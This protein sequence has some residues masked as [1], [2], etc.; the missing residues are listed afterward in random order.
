ML[1]WLLMFVA[2]CRCVK[3]QVITILVS[4]T[5]A[6][7]PWY[8]IGPF[9]RQHTQCTHCAR[10][11]LAPVMLCVHAQ[12]PSHHA[13]ALLQL[14]T[15][16]NYSFCFGCCT[17]ACK[18]GTAS[19]LALCTPLHVLQVGLWIL[20]STWQLFDCY[21]KNQLAQHPMFAFTANQHAAAA[22]HMASQPAAAP[23]EPVNPFAYGGTPGSYQPPVV[24]G[25]P[26]PQHYPTAAGRV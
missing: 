7:A 26:A 19:D 14:C 9:F 20:W 16:C 3:F 13:A 24:Q 15:C 25:Y 18:L 21:R 12:Q 6:A 23:A 11:M 8:S 4:K 2:A 22:V 10:G 5:A 1:N 17:P